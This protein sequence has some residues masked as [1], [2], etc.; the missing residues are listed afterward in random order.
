LKTGSILHDF[1][2]QENDDPAFCHPMNSYASCTPVIEQGRIYVHF[3]CYLTACFDT[4]TGKALWRREDLECDHH[5]GPASSPIV[6][7]GKLFVAYDGYDQQYVIALDKQTGETVWK[8]NREIE[9]GTDDGDRKKAYCTGAIIRVGG[10]D[11]LVYPSAVATIAYD[12]SNG[13]TL[14]TVYHG[15]MNASARPIFDGQRVFLTNGMGA[16]VAALPG[17]IDAADRARVQWE[18]QKQIAKK[19]S[20]L[21]IDDLL[22]FGAD[23]GVLSARDAATGKI[24]WLKRAN[25]EFAASPVFAGGRIYF[26]ARDG[27]IFTLKP[28]RQ[29][30]Q[31]ARGHL[32]SGFMASPAIVPDGMVLRGKEYL[33]LVTSKKA[34]N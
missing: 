15:G 10:K 9:Y 13:D 8:R 26:C 28:G 12:P 33:Y 31:L 2:V 5:R 32:G 11:Q 16:M 7:D 19:S 23:N 17:E 21:L 3:G 20:P 18:S 25:V 27:S 4:A 29:F 24:V 22:Y 30:Q 1:V 6:H 34:S 14:W